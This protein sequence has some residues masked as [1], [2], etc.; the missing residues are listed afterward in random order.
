MLRVLSCLCSQRVRESS[1]RRSQNL[2]SHHRK[3]RP[4][5]T[6]LEVLTS[7]HAQALADYFFIKYRGPDCFMQ[8][9]QR[10]EQFA[11]EFTS[12]CKQ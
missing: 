6:P 3:L 7:L 9:T 4:L 5:N 8:Q 11:G 1:P 12:I 2:P 10:T